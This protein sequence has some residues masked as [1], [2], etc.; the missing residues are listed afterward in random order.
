MREGLLDWVIRRA[1][2]SQGA[3]LAVLRPK[4]MLRLCPCLMGLEYHDLPEL[5]RFIFSS[6]SAWRR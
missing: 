5:R 3:V 4:E 6:F 2:S 1:W